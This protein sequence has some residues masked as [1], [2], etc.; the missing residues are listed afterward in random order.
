SQFAQRQPERREAGS[1][2]RI[3]FGLPHQHADAIDLAAL[4]RM[5]CE[6][7]RRSDAPKQRDE[8][9]ALHSITPPA[10]CSK[11]HGTSSPSAFAV[12]RLMTS[13]NLVG[14]S[15]GRSAGLA[16]LRILST[17][18]ARRAKLSRKIGP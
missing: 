18:T 4:L 12:F 9:P 3:A 1:V 15:T 11:N 10:R 14:C 7:P 2:F 16:P 13:S 5:R 8:L 6:R 17:K